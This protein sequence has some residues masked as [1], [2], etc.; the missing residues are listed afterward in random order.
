MALYDLWLDA[1]LHI[2][3]PTTKL[4]VGIH[5]PNS[6]IIQGSTLYTTE[7]SSATR[8]K[9]Y[10]A[11]CHNVVGSENIMLSEISQRL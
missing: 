7:F 2:L 3:T 11:I 6:I 10:P 5:V 4:Y 9:K 8:G 1:K